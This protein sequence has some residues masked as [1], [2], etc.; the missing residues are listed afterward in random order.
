MSPSADPASK[1]TTTYSRPV[2]VTASLFVAALV[3]RVFGVGA[4]AVVARHGADEA[5]AIFVSIDWLDG[6][7]DLYSPAPQSV[8]ADDDAEMGAGGRLFTRVLERRPDG[9]VQAVLAKEIRFD[10]DLPGWS[11]S[12]TGRDAPSSTPRGKAGEAEK[13]SKSL[14]WHPNESGSA[15]ASQPTPKGGHSDE[16]VHGP[17]HGAGGGDAAD[18]GGVDPGAAKGRDGRVAEVGGQEQ[19]GD[20]QCMGGPLGK[21]KR[22]TAAGAK[23]AHNDIGGYTLIQADSADAAAKIFAGHPHFQMSKDAYI[24]IVEVMPMPGM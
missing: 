19:E 4:E 15:L 2:R 17:V 16:T 21:T 22:V 6:T 5:G 7:L 9:E 10:P 14:P 1:S 3:R 11:P 8:F 24:D 20:R 23:D 18:D 13:C 12:R